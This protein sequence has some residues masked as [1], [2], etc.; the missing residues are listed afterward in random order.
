M[1]KREARPAL[2]QNLMQIVTCSKTGLAQFS[3]LETEKVYREEASAA[4]YKKSTYVRRIVLALSVFR[5]VAIALY[6]GRVKFF[7]GVVVGLHT[8]I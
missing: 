3:S 6:T 7:F 4:L 1:V 5:L 2:E 8:P